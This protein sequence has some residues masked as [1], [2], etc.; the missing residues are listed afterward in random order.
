MMKNGQTKYTILIVDWDVFHEWNGAP[1]PQHNHVI[2]S[3]ATDC[4]LTPDEII[5]LLCQSDMI[6]DDLIHF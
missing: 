4:A 6:L 3:S 2:E 1:P 5:Y